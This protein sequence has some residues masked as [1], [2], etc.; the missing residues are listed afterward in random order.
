MTTH[1]HY[2]HLDSSTDKPTGP[3]AKRFGTVGWGYSS[4][5]EAIRRCPPGSYVQERF[6]NSSND[7]AGHIKFVNPLPEEVA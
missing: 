6:C 2:V 5:K 3:R 4:L 7:W 1:T